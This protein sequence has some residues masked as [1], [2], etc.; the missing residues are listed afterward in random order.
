[1]HFTEYDTRLAAYA[2]LVN[3]AGE[4]LLTWF[5]GGADRAN[6]CWSVPGGGVEFDEGIED[7]VVRETYEETGYDVQV[8][9]LLATHHFTGPASRRASRPFR[10][11]RL[12]FEATIVGGRLG[13]TEQDGT[14]D[15]ARWV[16]LADFPL[17]E[18]TADVVDVAVERLRP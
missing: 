18:P 8:G 5:N 4:I 14:T 16:R 10:S 7:A 1:M 2:V 17:P 6:A 9:P 12:L 13:T 11:Q 3:D 15:F